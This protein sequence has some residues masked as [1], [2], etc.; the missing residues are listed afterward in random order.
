MCTFVND[1]NGIFT[2]RNANIWDVEQSA[3][4]VEKAGGIVFYDDGTDIFP[5]D[6]NRLKV[7]TDENN[8]KFLI[9]DSNIACSK[10][11]KDKI[12]KLIK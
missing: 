12:L 9:I 5:I 8:N 10:K 2:R 6:I 3:Y 11:M 1:L 7:K 4:I